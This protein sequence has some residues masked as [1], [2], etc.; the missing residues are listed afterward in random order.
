MRV[1]WKLRK[2]VQLQQRPCHEC[3]G[4][5]EPAMSQQWPNWNSNSDYVGTGT[6]AG[7]SAGAGADVGQLLLGETGVLRGLRNL[8]LCLRVPV[9]LWFRRSGDFA[10]VVFDGLLQARLGEALLQELGVGA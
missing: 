8:F 3:D 5:A 1:I 6:G 2:A 10:V 9:P 4:T 7:T